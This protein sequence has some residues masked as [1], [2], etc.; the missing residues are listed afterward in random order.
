[1]NKIFK[2]L[3]EE[4]GLLR[5]LMIRKLIEVLKK[6]EIKYYFNDIGAGV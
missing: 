1:M 2:K 3:L 4:Q 6:K 5:K